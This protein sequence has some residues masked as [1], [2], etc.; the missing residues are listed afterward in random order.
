MVNF[1]PTTRRWYD[2]GNPR[3]AGE[4]GACQR[5]LTLFLFSLRGEKCVVIRHMLLEMG[6]RNVGRGT[7]A[8]YLSAY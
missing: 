2:R 6:K 4:R 8:K 5:I 3:D 1:A 7:P